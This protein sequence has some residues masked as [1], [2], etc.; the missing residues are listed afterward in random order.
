MKVG[1]CPA[2]PF[3]IHDMHGNVWEWCRDWYYR[4]LPGGADP[5][6]SKEPGERNRDGTLSISGY[7]GERLGLRM[8]GRTRR[9][10]GYGLSRNA[11]AITSGFAWLRYGESRGVRAIRS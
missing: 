7:G 4:T 11:A 1:S 10:C 5:D 6:L 3:G 9:R 2:N 8:A